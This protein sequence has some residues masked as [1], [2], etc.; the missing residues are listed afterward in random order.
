VIQFEAPEFAAWSVFYT[1]IGVSVFWAKWGRSRLRPYVLPDVIG[2]LRLSPQ[3]RAAL[4]F[5]VFLFIGC[6]VGIAALEPKNA[7]QAIT[8]GFGWTGI[9]A[10]PEL[11]PGGEHRGS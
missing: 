5:L 9:F 4:E 10:H 11:R 1:A 6:C 8:A 2:L 7:V 3:A